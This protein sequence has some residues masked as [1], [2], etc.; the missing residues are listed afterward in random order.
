MVWTTLEEWSARRIPSGRQLSLC[1]YRSV[2]S[3]VGPWRSRFDISAGFGVPPHVTVVY[4]FLP[5]E[6]IGDLE[7]RSLQ[8]IFAA[9]HGF[10]VTFAR[11]GEFPDTTGRAGPLLPLGPPSDPVC[12]SRRRS[13][14]GA[15]WCSTDTGGSR[16]SPCP[17]G[18]DPTLWKDKRCVT[19]GLSTTKPA[20]SPTPMGP[21]VWPG[22]GRA[23]GRYRR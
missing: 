14:P 16:K 11:F 13:G 7:A 9:E 17:C 4:P 2:D 6:L 20:H 19:M 12:P 21:T 22:D 5:V 1:R 3:L 15:C 8:G 18:S 23:L 10:S